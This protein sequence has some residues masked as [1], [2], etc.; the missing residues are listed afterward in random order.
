MEEIVLIIVIGYILTMHL[1]TI[2]TQRYSY[3]HIRTQAQSF[4]NGHAVIRPNPTKPNLTIQI[5]Y[6]YIINEEVNTFT[7][8]KFKL[9]HKHLATT[10]LTYGPSALQERLEEFMIGEQQSE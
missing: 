10:S 7:I 1:R 5:Y 3:R 2:T 4:D 6:I 8:E 9:Y